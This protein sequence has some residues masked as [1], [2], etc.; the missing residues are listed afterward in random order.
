MFEENTNK[1]MK[2]DYTEYCIHKLRMDIILD[3]CITLIKKEN[4]P[5]A[6]RRA[7]INP[8]EQYKS[9]SAHRALSLKEL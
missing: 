1:L 9:F 5:V 4:T 2:R 7:A 8:T 6:V 3:I